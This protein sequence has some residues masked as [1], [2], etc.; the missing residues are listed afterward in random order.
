MEEIIAVKAACGKHILK[1]IVETCYLTE[2]E[3][4]M[5]CQSVTV[6]GADYIKTS[7]GF[8]TGGATAEDIQLFAQNVGKNVKIKAAGGIKTREDMEL[9]AELG[10]SRLGTSRG[11]R[12]LSG[13]KK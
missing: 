7:T 8:G 5:L 12:I 1:V 11:V 4:I 9:F 2:D 13:K 6:A 10:A 3:K